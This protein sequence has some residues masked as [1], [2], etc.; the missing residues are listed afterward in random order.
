MFESHMCSINVRLINSHIMIDHVFM[1]L[2]LGIPNIKI[3]GHFAYHLHEND[4]TY[5]DCLVTIVLL[6]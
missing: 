5:T 2:N 3:I 1:E 6:N 4:V